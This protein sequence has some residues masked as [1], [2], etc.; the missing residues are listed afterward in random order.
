[1]H[2]AAAPV[3]VAAYGEDIARVQDVPEEFAAVRRVAV[4]ASLNAAPR[5][6]GVYVLGGNELQGVQHSL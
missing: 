2:A 1:M 6:V 3:P 4:M 5:S